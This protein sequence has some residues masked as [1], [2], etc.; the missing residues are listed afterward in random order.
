MVA[1]SP[2]SLVGH[3][4]AQL[5]HVAVDT[6]QLGTK[7]ENAAALPSDRLILI[8]ATVLKDRINHDL[9]CLTSGDDLFPWTLVRSPS[10]N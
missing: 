6:T 3:A 5:I 7:I 8:E 9:I 1:L 2:G 10:G 4:H